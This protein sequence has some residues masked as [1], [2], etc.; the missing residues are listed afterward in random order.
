[1]IHT[2]QLGQFGLSRPVINGYFGWT[3]ALLATPP[4]LWS[5]ETSTVGVSGG[6]ATSWSDIS[7][8]TWDWV[9]TGNPT[10]NAAGLNG[11]RTLTFNGGSNR[12]T[13]SGDVAA[14]D[15]FKQVAVGWV[16]TIYKKNTQAAG[17]RYLF[18]S[19]TPTAGSTR[20]S[21][22]CGNATDGNA[23]EI[24]A[25]RA[26]VDAAAV[27]TEATPYSLTD[28]TLRLDYIDW[29]NR[30]AFIYT[31]GAL[32]TSNTT[33]TSAGATTDN[34][35]ANRDLSLGSIQ[36]G[37]NFGA[38]EINEIGVGVGALTAT[39]IDQIFGYMAWRT[40]LQS[41]LPVGHAYKTAPP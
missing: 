16:F 13:T 15:I 29:A 31:N 37:G 25:R 17:L 40:G 32:D 19:E 33:F 20:F 39:E 35:S 8:N 18:V 21:C 34:T 10:I 2:L 12:M 14:R 1:M 26:D 28:F 27:L 22:A 36:T 24:R 5:N 7:G 30:D 9:S 4:K 38:F 6:G 3:P 23:P 41:L 11:L